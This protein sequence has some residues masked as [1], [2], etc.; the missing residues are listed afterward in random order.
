MV[1]KLQL[2]FPILS[3]PGG[4][5]ATK[6]YG[7][8]DDDA[9]KHARPAVV[10]VGPDGEEA[11]RTVG[12]DFADRPVEDDVVAAVERL[13]LEAVDPEPP[14]PGSPKPGE[15]A[16]RREW[17]VPYYRGAGFALRAIAGRVPEASDEAERVGA[18][19]KRYGEAAQQL[20]G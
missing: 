10:V 14:R 13:G 3:D 7:V 15:R 6:P 5:R 18:T 16:F 1:E 12:R 19:V 11:F 20:T 2:P 4:E 17:M 9:D 8:W